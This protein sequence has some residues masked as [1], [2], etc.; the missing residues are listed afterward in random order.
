MAAFCPLASSLFQ[1][2]CCLCLLPETWNLKHQSSVLHH[3]DTDS[4]SF[5]LSGA[6]FP[7]TRGVLWGRPSSG[8]EAC[9]ALPMDKACLS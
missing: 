5:P 4:S 2:F 3:V 9:R 7:L 6:V 8:L 1:L